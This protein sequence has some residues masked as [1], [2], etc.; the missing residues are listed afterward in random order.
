[1]P[2]FLFYILLLIY[3]V[4]FIHC[5]INFIFLQGT[6]E[7]PKGSLYTGDTIEVKYRVIN[8]SIFPITY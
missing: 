7:I 3:A 6:V 1:M 5:L 8:N 2:Y 4:P